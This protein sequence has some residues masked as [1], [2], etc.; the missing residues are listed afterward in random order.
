MAIVVHAL[1]PDSMVKPVGGLGEQ[2]RQVHKRL[3]D[4]IDYYVMGFPEEEELEKYCG[5]YDIFPMIE[6]SA[7]NTIGNQINYFYSSIT[8]P[9]K[10][11]IIHALDYTTYVAGVF[12]SRFWKVPLVVTMNLSIQELGKRD[13]F[14][15][16]NYFEY[17]GQSVHNMMEVS[18]IMGMFCADKIIQVSKAYSELFKEF[19]NKTT[20]IPNGIDLD[21]WEK[22]Y[23]KYNFEGKN[24][25][26]VVFIGRFAQMKGIESLCASK[27]PEGIDLFFVGDNR[28]CESWCYDLVMD[29][30]K[31]K[32]VFHIDYAYGDVKRDILK[33]ADAVIMPSIH[34][35]FGIVGL[36][37][38]AAKTILLS[39]Y[40]DGIKEYLTEDAGIFCGTTKQTIQSALVKLQ[41]LTQ[42]QKNKIVE[43]GYQIAKKFDWNILVEKYL[44]L[45]KSLI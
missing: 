23:N 36:E 16:S 29:K 20:I 31:E 19:E 39:S 32:N 24:K 33:S 8:C 1:F 41:N 40:E 17:D 21:F 38:L 45:Y 2:F 37:T 43:N 34:E 18:E 10:P 25:I 44:S 26:K 6:H 7:V 13:M 42:E 11:D 4:K 5:V 30:C 9:K 12:A 35:P 27:I 15:C 28:G 22:P 14:Y 3:K